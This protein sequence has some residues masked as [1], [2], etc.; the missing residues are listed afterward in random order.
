MNDKELYNIAK[1]AVREEE[2]KGADIPAI[3]LYVDQ[4]INLVADKTQLS[5]E[6]YHD[7]QLTKTM[8]NN[9]SK[10]GLI[11]PIKGKKYSKEQIVQILTVYTL[12]N[13]L[14][15]GEI[16]RL[17][18][19]AYALEDFSGDELVKIYDRYIDIKTENREY[20]QGILKELIKN[21]SLNIEDEK[22]FMLVVGS[23]LSLSGFLKNIAQALIDE[24]YPIPEEPEE[25]EEREEK[26]KKDK[27]EKIK[28]KEEKEKKKEKKKEESKEKAAENK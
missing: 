24:K 18:D 4:I 9:Y 14:S 27:A 20:S 17:L 26:P 15:I 11:T 25:K 3:D 12:K 22:D 8:I 21:N 28:E 19:G 1:E 10:D 13:T 23:L 7:K 2:L 5:S 16:K 6:R